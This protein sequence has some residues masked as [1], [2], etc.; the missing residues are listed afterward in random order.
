MNAHFVLQAGAINTVARTQRAVV[1]D[2]EF[3]H[4]K[5][6]DAFAALRRIGQAGQH[7]VK[8]VVSHVVLTCAD[9]NLVAGELVSAVSLGRCT[10]SQQPQVSSALRLCQAHGARPLAAGELG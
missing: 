7:Q 6:A 10:G 9:E 3:G 8:D 2:I 1:I 5:Q 4:R